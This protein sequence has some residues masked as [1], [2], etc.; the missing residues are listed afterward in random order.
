MHYL[1]YLPSDVSAD[2]ELR[3]KVFRAIYIESNSFLY[4]FV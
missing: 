1:D 4:L 2:M 3:N